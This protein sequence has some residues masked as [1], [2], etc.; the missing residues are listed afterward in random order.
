MYIPIYYIHLYSIYLYTIYI[1]IYIYINTD[2]YVKDTDS[3][4]YLHYTSAHPYHTKMSV[5]FS[6]AL[7]FSHLC[8]LEKDFERHMAGMKQWFA[9]RDY[10]QDLINSEINK[11]KFLYVENK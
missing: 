2:L 5:V 10:P 9:K 4:Q 1:Y 11:V 3:H 7:R 6:R 8:A